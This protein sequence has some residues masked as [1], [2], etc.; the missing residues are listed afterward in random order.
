MWKKGITEDGYQVKSNNRRIVLS[1]NVSLI[2]QE[3]SLMF[4]S[5]GYPIC[6]PIFMTIR[7][8]VLLIYFARF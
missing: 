6:I 4:I 8:K 3:T 1:L 5:K 2:L 7:I